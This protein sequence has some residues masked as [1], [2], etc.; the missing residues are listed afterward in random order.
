MADGNNKTGGII[1]SRKMARETAMKLI[2]QM[3]MQSSNS[4]DT[5]NLY[6]ENIKNDIKEDDKSYISNCLHGVEGNLKIIDGYIEK[7]AR[8]WKINRIGKVEL[9]ILRL[10]IYEMLYINDIP[11]AVSIN[12]AV[13]IAK[14]YCGSESPSFING[15]LDSVLKEIERA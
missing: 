2:Y 12:E 3:D 13:D 4:N 11:R 5:L 14:K 1:M 6:F 7:Y 10:S 9:A 15:I 8:G